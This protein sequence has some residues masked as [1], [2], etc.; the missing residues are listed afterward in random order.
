MYRAPRIDPDERRRITAPVR[1]RPPARPAPARSRRRWWLLKWTIILTVWGAI[2]GGLGLLWFAWDLPRPEAALDAARRPSLTLEDRSGQIFATFGDVVGDPLRLSD[3]PPYLPAAAVSVEDRR[4]WSHAGLDLIGIAR[5][6][7]VNLRAG[8]VVQGG[9]T[10]TQQVAKNLFLTNARTFRRKV[11]EVLLTLWLERHF[12]K[13]EILEIWL[14]RVY[15]GSGAWGVDAAAKLYFGV[16]ARRV[17]L[18]QAAVIAGLPRAPSRFS[19]RVDPAA[20]AARGREVL[21]AMAETGA[22]TQ[23]QAQAASAQIAF[24]TRPGTAAGWFSDWASEKAEALMTPGADAV[25]RTTLD[26]R[27][28]TVVETKLAA[29]LDGPGAAVNAGQAAVVVLEAATGAVRAMA[30]GRDYRASPF[31]R[32]VLARRQPGSSFKPFVWLA[33]LEKGARPDDIV[34]DAPIRI[35]TWSPSNFEGRFRGE[36]TLEEALAHSVNT[37]SVRLLLQVG[38][39][40]VVA[41][42]ARRL[43]ITDQLPA[44]ASLALGTGEV[45]LL[46]LAGAYASFFNGGML[47]K[48]T[49]LEAVQVEGKPLPLPRP[50]PTRVVDPDLAAMMVRMMAAVVSRGSG[51]AA[52][53]PG[54]LVAGKTGTTQDYRDAWFV[55]STG[56]LVIGVWMGNDDNKPMKDVVGGSLPARLFHDIA[57]EIV[58]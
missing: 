18:W 30:G 34:L 21:A 11:Q 10:I 40:R 27:M 36:I 33:A 39:P 26:L 41:E 22:I 16:S 6:G 29:I 1:P 25:L 56:G 55:G 57:Q 51:T 35:G 45:G 13:Q 43:G 3:L 15:L 19:P 31:N 28:Q 24:P 38:G 4:F 50:A 49:G 44:N 54:R 17:T 58:R 42:V 5:A 8:R 23:E 20:A 2:A 48:P 32:A 9:S 52:A 14:N 7:F 53:L 37:A 47:V 12:T 46:E